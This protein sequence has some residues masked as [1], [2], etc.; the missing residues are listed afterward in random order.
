MTNPS[1]PVACPHPMGLVH[2]EEQRVGGCLEEGQPFVYRTL[3]RCR[4]CSA[5]LTSDE[6]STLNYLLRLIQ[7]GRR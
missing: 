7:E 2:V 6:A 5:W 1:R 3:L 4:G